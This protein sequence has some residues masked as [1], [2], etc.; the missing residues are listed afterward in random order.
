MDWR[1]KPA[2]IDVKYTN[3]AN[4]VA[5]QRRYCHQSLSSTKSVLYKLLESSGNIR[6]NKRH[7]SHN[8]KQYTPS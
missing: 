5:I 1:D 6:L 8:S 3:M 2:Y 4:A 7:K